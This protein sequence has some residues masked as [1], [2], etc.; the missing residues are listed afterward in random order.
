MIP[1]DPYNYDGDWP[2]A[3]SGAYEKPYYPP[4]KDQ[5]RRIDAQRFGADFGVLNPNDAVTVMAYRKA[6][7]PYV[8]GVAR[9]AKACGSSKIDPTLASVHASEADTLVFLWNQNSGLSNADI[10]LRAEGILANMQ[11]TVKQAS[12]IA[13]GL[14]RD[15]PTIAIPSSPSPDIQASVLGALQGLGVATSGG[16]QILQTGAGG[17]LQTVEAFVPGSGVTAPGFLGAP[18]DQIK[19][20][21]VIAAVVYVGAMAIPILA[22]VVMGAFTKKVL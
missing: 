18:I 20:Y 8:M 22:P 11:D 1:G 19:K 4:T 16:G 6:W 9:A 3:G 12:S 21:L 15:C 10:V 7:D 17:S 13:V 2:R 5:K 14:K